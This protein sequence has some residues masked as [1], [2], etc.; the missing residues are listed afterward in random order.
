MRGHDVATGEA[1][2]A[3]KKTVFCLKTNQTKLLTLPMVMLEM[4]Q[5]LL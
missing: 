2:A 3:W 1:L 5:I 4:V